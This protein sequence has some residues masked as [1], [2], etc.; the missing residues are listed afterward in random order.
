M[1]A[2]REGLFHAYPAEIGL[3]EQGSSNLA[4]YT[5]LFR[6]F[7]EKQNGQW[8]DIA[9]E[10]MEITGWF[11]LETKDGRVNDFAIE[12]LKAA[13]GWDGRDPFWLQDNAEALR[14]HAVQVKLGW[15]EYNDNTNLKVQFLNPYGSTGGGVSKADDG[16]RRNI[17]NRL[18]SKLRALSGGSPAPAPKPAGRPAPPKPAPSRATAAT[19]PQVAEAT[20]N[21]AWAEF[22]KA[23][24]GEKWT[25][26]AIEAEWF[27][28]IA[29]MFGGKQPDALSPADWGKMKAEGPG[30]II[31]F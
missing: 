2:N 16:T 11:Y 26:E 15:E 22:C 10:S 19:K 25:Q 23:S 3:D 1:L 5:I 18:G 30:M 31:P 7:E 21:E 9:G 13:F 4:C 24:G 17:S 27:R 6:I 29:D 8:L 20:M 14:E 12:A 28:I